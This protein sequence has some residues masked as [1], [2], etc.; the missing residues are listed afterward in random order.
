MRVGEG[1]PLRQKL[2]PE[3]VEVHLAFGYLALC[4]MHGRLWVEEMFL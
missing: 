1:V 2:D 4:V 3:T